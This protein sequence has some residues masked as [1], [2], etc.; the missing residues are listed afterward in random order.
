MAENELIPSDD[1]IRSEAREADWS[2]LLARA[3]DDLTRLAHSE[4]RLLVAELKTVAHEELADLKVG[5]HAEVAELKTVLHQE[6]DRVLAFIAA[7]VLM[8]VGAGCILAAAIQFFHEF[9]M[10]PW[11]QSFG[12]VG[13]ALF[14]IAIAFPGFASRR[15]KT[16]AMV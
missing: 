12:I 11:W 5:V 3:V 1:R 4:I 6:T 15:R 16:P 2:S 7:G 10:L 13:L 9:V 14:A 8:M